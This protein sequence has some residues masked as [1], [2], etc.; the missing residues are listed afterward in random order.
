MTERQTDT[1][2]DQSH[3]TLAHLV[4]HNGRVITGIKVLKS[5]LHVVSNVMQF[6]FLIMCLESQQWP[7]DSN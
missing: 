1:Q 7:R 6:L 4:Q 3:L 5:S 2:T